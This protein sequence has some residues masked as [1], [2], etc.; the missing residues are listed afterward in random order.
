[1]NDAVTVEKDGPVRVLTLNRP[2]S[3]NAFCTMNR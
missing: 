2:D 1:M 3:M